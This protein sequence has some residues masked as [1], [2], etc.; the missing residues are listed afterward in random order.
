LKGFPALSSIEWRSIA[1]EKHYSETLTG[2]EAKRNS[3]PSYKI[4]NAKG[5]LKHLYIQ[6]GNDQGGRG[7]VQDI[8][9]AAQIAAYESFIA[10][11]EKILP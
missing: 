10:G 1:Y 2:L 9:L 8:C 7:E 3:D 5:V 4:E 6:E 11:W